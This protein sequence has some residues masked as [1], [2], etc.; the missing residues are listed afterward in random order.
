MTLLDRWLVIFKKIPRDYRCSL[1]SSISDDELDNLARAVQQQ[2]PGVGIRLLTG[3][4]RSIGHRFQREKMRLCLLRT[5]PTGVLC[6]WKESIK[7]R[8]Y[9]VYAPQF[10]WHIDGNHKLIR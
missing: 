5:D 1:T 10:L 7:R 4:L 6:R 8:V 2:P 9:N 3:H